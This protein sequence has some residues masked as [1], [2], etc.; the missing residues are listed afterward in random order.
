MELGL[1]HTFERNDTIAAI[2]S[3]KYSNVRI[4]LSSD[5]R[6]PIESPVYVASTSYFPKQNYGEGLFW[7]WNKVADVINATIPEKSP[8]MEF[9]A[10]CWYFGKSLADIMEEEV[11]AEADKYKGD[12]AV[13]LGMMGVSVGGTEIEQWV[14][15]KSQ[16]NCQNISCMGANCSTN[17]GLY[18]GMVA[19]YVNMTVKGWIWCECYFK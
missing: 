1:Q 5:V 3:G 4:F 16:A 7:K 8:L 2:A 17:A 19:P 15:K 6:T 9:S 14:E 11:D 13:P 10:A 12:G 18:N